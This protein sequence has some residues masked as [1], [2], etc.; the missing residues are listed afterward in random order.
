MSERVNRY[1][2]PIGLEIKGWSERQRPPR[3]AMHGRYCRVEPI[4][5]E[6]DAV[7]LCAAYLEAP[8][9]RD[10]TYLPDERPRSE[11]QFRDYLSKLA[12]SDDPLHHTIIDASTGKAVG[13]AALMRINPPNGVIE[14]GYITYSPRL[15]GTRVGTEAMYLLMRRVF[16]ELGYRRYEWKC[17]SLNAA[18]RKAAVRYGFTFEG[19][20]RNALIY[21]GRN[22][23]TAWYSIVAAEWPRV[24]A[25]FETWLDPD[26]FDVAG[27]QKR[28]LSSLHGAST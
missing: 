13:T 27:R 19:I 7:D 12:V 16:A 22:R 8:D 9:D 15:K 20:F 28:R 11:L 2:Q 10:W 14:V 23:D 24:R 18:S 3:S 1:G 26:N 21:K 6:R 5:L 25:A 4:D 17:D